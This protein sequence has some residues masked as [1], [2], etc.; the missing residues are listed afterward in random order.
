MEHR[1]S[2]RDARD[3]ATQ[4]LRQWPS[5]AFFRPMLRGP[6]RTAHHSVDED[7]EGGPPLLNELGGHLQVGKKGEPACEGGQTASCCRC[8]CAVPSN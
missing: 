2:R 8:A 6:A 3:A 4:R 5:C 1:E 7:G